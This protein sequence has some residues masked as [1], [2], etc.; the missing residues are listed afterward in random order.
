VINH[1]VRFLFGMAGNAAIEV[2]RNFGYAQRVRHHNNRPLRLARPW[3]RIKDMPAVVILAIWS[4]K[5]SLT[6]GQNIRY[7]SDSLM[8]LIACALRLRIAHEV[9][10]CR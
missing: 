9:N 2:V 3:S 8:P 7:L 6:T 10:A 4:R 1:I 5:P